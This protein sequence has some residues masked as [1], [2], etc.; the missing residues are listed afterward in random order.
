MTTTNDTELQVL[1]A[2]VGAPVVAFERAGWGFENRTDVVTLADGRRLVVQRLNRRVQ[3][4]RS[5][6]LAQ[7]LPDRLAPFGIRLPRQL[8]ASAAAD[9]PYAVREHLSGASAAAFMGDAAGAVAVASAM[10]ALL[11]QLQQVLAT[12]LRLPSSWADAPRLEQQ[13]RRQL[14]RCRGMF[15]EATRRELAKTIDEVRGYFTG[16]WACFAHGDFCPVNALV[17]TT[18]VRRTT[19]G[20]QPPLPHGSGQA[21]TGSE[22]QEPSYYRLRATDR[23]RDTQPSRGYPARNTQHRSLRVVGLLDVDYARVAD[24]L[25]DAAWWG[26]VVRYHHPERWIVA[27]PELLRAAAIAVDQAMLGRVRVLQRLR[28]LE[29]VDDARRAS[30]DAAIMWARRLHETLAWEDV[31]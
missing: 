23:S 14:N 18:D 6:R 28:C 20:H 3:A 8:A 25:F 21:T 11:P 13:A 9:P 1:S 26:W 31:L 24:P 2:I 30:A 19:T 15:D 17:E 5:L 29:A 16:R 4:R 12:G 27:W 7:T 22:E 10:G